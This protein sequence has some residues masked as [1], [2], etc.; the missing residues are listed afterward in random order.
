[1]EDDGKSLVMESEET[2]SWTSLPL[3]P[4]TL[5]PFQE[6]EAQ[7]KVTTGGT[8]GVC[9]LKASSY[10]QYGSQDM[11]VGAWALLCPASPAEADPPSGRSALDP[12]H[13]HRPAAL[14]HSRVGWECPGWWDETWE[15]GGRESQT[16]GWI[17]SV[18]PWGDLALL[19]LG[20]HMTLLLQA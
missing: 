20:P 9:S 14:H 18:L 4:P 17:T 7:V 13:L 19:A 12:P 8:S 6:I 10:L 3:I 11:G 16:K 15:A 1:M 2:L 5:K